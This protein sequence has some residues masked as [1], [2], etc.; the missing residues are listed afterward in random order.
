MPFYGTLI[1]VSGLISILLIA[2]F[3]QYNFDLVSNLANAYSNLLNLEAF[4]NAMNGQ[5]ESW[6]YTIYSYSNIDDV[7][8]TVSNN[9]A[10]ISTKIRPIAYSVVDKN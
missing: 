3:H 1:L 8:M 9:I 6:I 2:N 4:Q 7:N 10:I 5:N